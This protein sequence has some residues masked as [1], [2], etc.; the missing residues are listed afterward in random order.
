MPTNYKQYNMRVKVDVNLNQ[1]LIVGANI[2]AIINN[3]HYTHIANGT[4]FINILLAN[5]TL[6][7]VYPNGLL[8][9]GRLG[10]SPLLLDQRGYK[11]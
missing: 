7:A 2:N 11:Y 5:P 3:S 6:P 1:Y 9:R 8:A 4:N 10:E